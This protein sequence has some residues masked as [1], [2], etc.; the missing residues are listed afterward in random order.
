MPITPSAGQTVNVY[1]GLTGVL[2]I[3]GTVTVSGTVAVS[4]TNQQGMTS[5]A[6]VWVT[7]TI[8][9]GGGNVNVTQSIPLT[10][11]S[12]LASPVWVTGIITQNNT[13]V[14]ITASIT[15]P[16][17]ATNPVTASISNFP[18]G[19]NSNITASIT[20]PV[21]MTNAITATLA[22]GGLNVNVTQS[23]PLVVTSTFGSPVWVT[24]STG[25]SAQ[26]EI[27]ASI[28]LTA[29]IS[30]AAFTSGGLEVFVVNQTSS[31]LS[32]VGIT[33]GALDVW[34]QN[35]QG[36]DVNITASIPIQVTSS[37]ANPVYVTGALNTSVQVYA[38]MPSDR[39]SSTGTLAQIAYNTASTLILAANAQRAGLSVYNSSSAELF[40][41]PTASV[42]TQSF[43]Y[44][45]APRAEFELPPPLYTGPIYGA[46]AAGGA[47][48]AQVTEYQSDPSSLSPTATLYVTSTQA[49]P[50]WTTG[51]VAANVTFPSALDVNITSS[52]PLTVTSTFA[53]PVWVTGNTGGSANVNVTQSIPLFVTST[54]AN[55][56]WVTGALL[57]N[58]GTSGGGLVEITASI[59][60]HVTSTFGQPLWV[61]GSTGGSSEVNVTASITLPVSMT[62]AVTA[63]VSNFPTGFN[64]NITASITLP[65]TSSAGAPLWVTGA[66]TVN[67]GSSSAGSTPA[68]T[69]TILTVT[70]TG[71]VGGVGLLASN[72]NR[73]LATVFNNASTNLYVSLGTGATTTAFQVL[74][75]PNAYYEVLNFTGAVSGAWAG[76][77]TGNALIGENT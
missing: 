12:T 74:L 5:G 73:K 44:R 24:G 59:P 3:T 40:L 50:V 70:A 32:G 22:G 67:T 31:S 63:S 7:G 17:S 8:T 23:V 39:T 54:F 15:L 35:S 1:A 69:G 51:S 21:S 57:V 58:T 14:R 60:L 42:T 30:G 2:P 18:A 20:L 16:V 76:T 10:V 72:S 53:A 71:T 19:F 65:V 13:D 56:L 9:Q 62:N 47:G 28:P 52:I 27:T 25:G 55:P 64:S 6:P 38:Y 61:T 46:W 75:V 43:S 41:A 37:M 4:Q 45:V 48:G 33:S 34:V 29:T 49:N 66:L 77:P 68:T 36:S 11:T 26:V